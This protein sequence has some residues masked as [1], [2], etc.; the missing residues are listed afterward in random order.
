MMMFRLLG[1]VFGG[2][3]QDVVANVGGCRRCKR[4]LVFNL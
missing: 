2:V 1:L 3:Q 4:G